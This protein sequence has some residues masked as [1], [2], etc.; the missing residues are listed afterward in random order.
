MSIEQRWMGGSDHFVCCDCNVVISDQQV[1][2]GGLLE[3]R[4][5]RGH[6][7]ARLHEPSV[8]F[9]QGLGWASVVILGLALA[10]RLSTSPPIETL[11]TANICCSIV[12][13]RKIL[14]GL[15]YRKLPKPSKILARQNFAEAIGAWTGVVLSTLLVLQ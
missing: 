2:H 3:N 13:C 7:V 4:C 8:G 11:R 6:T 12:A 15:T 5:P 10:S 14:R 9:L 1:R